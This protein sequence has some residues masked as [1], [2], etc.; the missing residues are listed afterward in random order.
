MKHHLCDTAWHIMTRTLFIPT[1]SGS[2]NIS[3]LNMSRVFSVGQLLFLNPAPTNV[4]SMSKFLWEMRVWH[5]RV[6]FCSLCAGQPS[7][8]LSDTPVESPDPFSA[9]SVSVKA[10]HRKDGC[11]LNI[12]RKI[13]F[14]VCQDELRSLCVCLSQFLSVSL[15]L[16]CVNTHTRHLVSPADMQTLADQLRQ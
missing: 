4:L 1:V 11:D 10:P 6:V 3:I 7:Q 13:C 5:S 2:R 9:A 14:Y 16:P 15:F 12:F 8:S